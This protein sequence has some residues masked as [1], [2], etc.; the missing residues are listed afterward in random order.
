MDRGDHVPL[1]GPTGRL[2]EARRLLRDAERV[3]VLTGAGISAESGVPT[4]RDAVDAHWRR[5]RPEELA[6]PEAFARNPVQVWAWYDSRRARLRECDP[7]AAHHALARWILDDPG[8]RRLYTQNV[9][10]LHHR[11]LVAAHDGSPVPS[12]A[13]PRE[14]HG[15]IFV[16]RCSECAWRERNDAAVDASSVETLPRCPE[17]GALA[18]PA[19]VWFGEALDGGILQQAMSDAQRAT[20]CLSVGTSA[21]V[22]PAASLPRI[23]LGAGGALIEVNPEPT[24]LSSQASIRI[25]GSAGSVL[26]ELL[27]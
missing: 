16:I 19:V 24:P 12:E 1:R 2:T 17:C 14:L 4:F 6:T 26:P 9:D 22:H 5:F 11:A 3:L 13:R 25:S 27:D 10:G 23:V 18:R 21:L 8:S 20:V 7:N 15:D